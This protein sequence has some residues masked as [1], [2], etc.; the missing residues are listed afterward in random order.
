M[1]SARLSCTPAVVQN[2]SP[3]SRSSKA[4]MR[5]PPHVYR[6]LLK[7]IN[8]TIDLPH[9]AVYVDFVRGQFKRGAAADSAVRLQLGDEAAKHLVSVDSHRK[10]LE[11]YN[12]TTNRDAG[13]RE[14]VESVARRV[15]LVVPN[16]GN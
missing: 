4:L 12:I 3:A 14:H 15:G 2:A 16:T 7:A 13:Q 1:L 6:S 10:V 8:R 9:S 5:P 11:R